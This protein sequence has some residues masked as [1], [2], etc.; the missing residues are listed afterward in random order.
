M[1][2]GS[3]L[4][5]LPVLLAQPAAD[6]AS[7]EPTTPLSFADL[8]AMTPLTPSRTSSTRSPAVTQGA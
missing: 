1:G 8:P 3:T 4:L 2:A 7:A 5:A 6:M